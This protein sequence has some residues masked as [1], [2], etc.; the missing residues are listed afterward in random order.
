MKCENLLGNRVDSI[1]R[2]LAYC[3][4]VIKESDNELVRA[5]AEGRDFFREGLRDLLVL[6]APFSKGAKPPKINP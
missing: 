1:D 5:L 4:K 6:Y 3:R 2:A